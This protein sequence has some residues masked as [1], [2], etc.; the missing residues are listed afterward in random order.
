VGAGESGEGGGGGDDA[1]ARLTRLPPLAR[2][3]ALRPSGS[4][5]SADAFALGARR[6]S[7]R[8]LPRRGLLPLLPL[9]HLPDSSDDEDD[10]ARSA[11]R[12]TGSVLCS[13]A[14]APVP[15]AGGR[16]EV[17]FMLGDP[18]LAF[19]SAPLAASN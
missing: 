18:R 10:L 3:I 16:P 9:L 19:R 15:E 4:G 6:P 13:L 17:R 1:L 12:L 7:T 2:L 14:S 8:L 5:N 11:R